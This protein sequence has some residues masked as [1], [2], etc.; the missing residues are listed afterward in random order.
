MALCKILIIWLLGVLAA[1][2]KSAIKQDALILPPCGNQ[3]E[4]Y[5]NRSL[6]IQYSCQINKG[7]AIAN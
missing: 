7:E 6:L 4:K 1:P 3:P 2:L 5:D